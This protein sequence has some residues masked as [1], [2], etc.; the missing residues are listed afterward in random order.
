MFFSGS[1]FWALSIAFPVALAIHALRTGRGGW[2][3]LIVFFPLVGGLIYLFVEVLPELRAGQKL[4]RVG[5]GVRSRVDPMREVRLLRERVAQAGTVANRM[6]LARAYARAGMADEAA[7][8]Y[9]EC[10]QGIYRDDPQALGELCAVLYEAGRRDE[11]REVMRTLLGRPGHLSPA[12]RLLNARMLEEAGV[13]DAALAE[14]QLLSRVAAGEEARC[15]YALLLRRVGR[16]A[17]ARAAFEAIVRDARGGSRA[18]R[19]AEKEWIATAEREL[20]R[21][22]GSA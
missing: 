18:F 15:R 13:T 20:K 3:F 5:S 21:T 1:L 7:A 16:E 14:Y 8:T 2:V 6:E 9:R 17:E 22:P 10:L 4:R 11:A 19:R 12:L